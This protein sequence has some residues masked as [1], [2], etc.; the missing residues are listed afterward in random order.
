MAIQTRLLEACKL[1]LS[2]SLPGSQLSARSVNQSL[3]CVL[4]MFRVGLAYTAEPYF[5]WRVS[6]ISFNPCMDGR[7]CSDHKCVSCIQTMS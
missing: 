2:L 7:Q 1:M 5:L 4:M 3:Q 6:A